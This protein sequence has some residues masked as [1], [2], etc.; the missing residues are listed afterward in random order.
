MVPLVEP[1]LIEPAVL[2]PMAALPGLA[3]VPLLAP[4]LIEPLV[5]LVVAEP[6]E[7]AV[8]EALMDAFPGTV[9]LFAPS[10]SVAETPLVVCVAAFVDCAIAM[11]VEAR[12]VQR[13]VVEINKR[14][15]LLAPKEFMFG[16]IFRIR[17]RRRHWCR[18]P[19]RRESYP[20]SQC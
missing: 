2:V 13:I 3:I 1:L 9:C 12:T 5:S 14:D 20:W 19:S 10:G 18:C 11:P 16:I 17:H 8:V 7:P 4:L 6:F 15:I